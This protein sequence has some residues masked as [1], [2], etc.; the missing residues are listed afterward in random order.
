MTKLCAK[1][2][3]SRYLRNSWHTWGF[4]VRWLRLKNSLSPVVPFG[5]IVLGQGEQVAG[6]IQLTH[7]LALGHDKAFLKQLAGPFDFAWRG[8]MG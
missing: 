1:M 3:H 7:T 5:Q 2:P 4:G 6:Q 8:S